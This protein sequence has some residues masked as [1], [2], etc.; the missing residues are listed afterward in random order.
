MPITING[1]GTL[2][3]INAGGYPDESVTTADLAASLDL[4]GKTIT[5]PDG[6]VKA[7]TSKLQTF[8]S[9]IVITSGSYTDTGI[10][11]THTPSTNTAKLI[12]NVMCRG[13]SAYGSEI[14]HFYRFRDG[15]N[16]NN[17]NIQAVWA[18]NTGT[19]NWNLNLT[20]I[21]EPGSA[22][23]QTIKLFGAQ[24]SGTSTQLVSPVALTVY[25]VES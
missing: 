4:D 25:E 20:D 22:T 13:A 3:G 5:L 16:N 24:A 10:F 6:H 17:L 1:S 8:N 19:G 18:V 9:N 14:S 7:V 15:S 21:W 23:E 12:I 11:I 2:T